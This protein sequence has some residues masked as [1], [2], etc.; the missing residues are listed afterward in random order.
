MIIL[1]MMIIFIIL[2][3]AA[4]TQNHV[5]WMKEIV[6]LMMNVM[7]ISYVAQTIALLRLTPL[8]TAAMT[9]QVFKD[10]IYLCIF[11]LLL[12]WILEILLISVKE[13]IRPIKSIFT[14]WFEFCLCP[15]NIW[16]ISEIVDSGQTKLIGEDLLI[17]EHGIGYLNLAFEAKKALKG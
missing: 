13:M 2:G 5:E 4:L 14:S 12:G 1:T 10:L 11:I 16:M 9:P 15:R 8:L 17:G 6:I 3:G 7:V